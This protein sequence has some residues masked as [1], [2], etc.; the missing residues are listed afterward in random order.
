MEYIK[1][2]EELYAAAAETEAV[3]LDT[4]WNAAQIAEAAVNADYSYVVAVEGGALCGVCSCIFSADEGEVLNL[5]VL[6]E[7]RRKGIGR[8]LLE[9]LRDEAC[10]R[11]CARLFLEVASRNEAALALY[12]AAGFEKAGIRKNF[13]SKQKD[14]AVI[15][16]S[17]L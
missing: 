9:A 8:A 4:A 6:P 2:T 5:A 7:H 14:D 13:Y 10:C 3:C 17:E 1:I 12:A 16:V 11:G 15:M